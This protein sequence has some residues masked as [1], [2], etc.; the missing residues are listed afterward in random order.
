MKELRPDSQRGS[1]TVLALGIVAA[2]TCLTGGVIAV[3][4]AT[5][6]KQRAMGAADLSALAAA[7]VAS[8]AHPGSPCPEAE[9]VARAN[10]AMLAACDVVRGIATVTASLDYLGFGVDAQAR[11]GP[12]QSKT[13]SR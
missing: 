12:S 1:A 8:G 11:A 3:A 13:A 10:G 2:L 5:V 7:D 9:R 6:A 4:G